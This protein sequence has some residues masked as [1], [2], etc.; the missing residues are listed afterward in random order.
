MI[1]KE[2]ELMSRHTTFKVGGPARYYLIPENTGE[3]RAAIDF[4]D[5][6]ELPY[7]VVGRGSNLLFSDREYHGVIIEIGEHFSDMSIHLNNTV[8]VKSGMTLTNMASRLAR[9]GLAGFEFAGGIPGTVG[10]AIVM[11]AGAYD[12][13]IKDTLVEVTVMNE[14]GE[15]VK[16]DADELELSYRHSILQEKN[17]IVL[18]GTFTFRSGSQDEIRAQI[19][20]YN[21]RRR[22]KQPLEYASAG[23][24]FKRP[25]GFFA[26]KLIE[27]AGL[28][29][30][31]IGGARVSD[32]HAGF[33]INTGDATA[34]EI[35]SLIEHVKRKVLEKSGVMLE[36]EVKMIGDFSWDLDIF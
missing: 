35:H 3:V 33:V 10:G 1:T 16:L 28:K 25:E 22:E 20:E 23:S 19:Q 15:L 5:E 14:K 17:W 27:D 12:G 18:S 4:A 32:K 34:S 11:N 2:Q 7:M 31:H 21:K 9:M 29:G 26:G 8:V 6:R 36:P 30:Y 13:E 24:T